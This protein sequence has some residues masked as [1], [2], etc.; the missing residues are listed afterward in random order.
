[1]NWV[2]FF[3]VL[4]G[5][6]AICTAISQSYKE[7][8]DSEDRLTDKNEII[9]LQK[10]N[11]D[12]LQKINNLQEEIISSSK[13]LIEANKRIETLNIEQLNY[14]SGG[15]SFGYVEVN[16]ILDNNG[17][18]NYSLAIGKEGK[19]PLYNV[20]V[21]YFDES[22]IKRPSERVKITDSSGNFIAYRATISDFDY[23]KTADI[24]DISQNDTRLFGNF[25][26]I[27]DNGKI[28]KINLTISSKNGSFSEILR[29]RK[30]GNEFSCAYRVN[31]ITDGKTKS[32][33]LKE[34]VGKNF[35]RTS[36]GKIKWE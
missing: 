26:K 36:D 23:H 24:G 17:V 15:D 28:V 21:D 22:D 18:E 16:S 7:R 10:S 32:K 4:T 31:S 5:I 33:I 11:N 9:Q 35:P 34:F 8:K 19:Y 3:S 25:F 12:E 6:L 30:I 27:E 1:M 2:M 20:K 14:E 13:K 29:M